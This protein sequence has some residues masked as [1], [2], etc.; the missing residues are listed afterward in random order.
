MAL[1]AIFYFLVKNSFVYNRLQKEIDEANREGK[2]S[3][4]VE[5][6]QGQQLPYL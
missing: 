4:V 2:F 5:F 1:R 6:S 3:E